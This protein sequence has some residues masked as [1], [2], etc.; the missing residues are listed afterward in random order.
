MAIMD[1]VTPVK[2][3]PKVRLIADWKKAWKF[4]SVRASLAGI[5]VM[6]VYTFANDI[7]YSLPLE[8]QERVPH[9]STVGMVLFALNIVF[10]IYKYVK[11]DED[12]NEVDA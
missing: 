8:V 3:T 7:W 9:A 2:T 4:S 10:R 1:E 12:G 11:V 5:G 6:G